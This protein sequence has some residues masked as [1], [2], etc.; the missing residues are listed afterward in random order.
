MAKT[1]KSQSNE[2]YSLDDVVDCQF[3]DPLK[4]EALEPR[5][6]PYWHWIKKCRHLGIHKSDDRICNWTARILTKDKRYIQKYLG[7]AIDTGRGVIDL[8]TAALRAFEWFETGE[9]KGIA[10]HARPT[11]RTSSVN[12]CPIGDTYTVGHALKEYTEWTKIARSEGGHYNNLMLINYHL[13]PRFIHILLENF[14]ATH[15]KDLAIQVLETPPKYGFAHVKPRIDPH[16]LNVDQVRKR[17]RT[18][19]SLVT[20]LRMAFRHA[21]DNGYI[22][23]ERP[24]RCLKRIAV[25]HSPRT[26][27]LTR[28]ECNS[29]L[30][31]CTPAL[32]TLVMAALYSGARVGELGRLTV[33][34]VGKIGY[35]IRIDAFKRSPARFVFLP[36]EGMSFFLE[37]CKGK[38]HRDHVFR[39]DMGKVWKKQHTTLFRRAVSKAG[40]PKE[41]V[42]HGLRHT[43]AS[44]LVR[45][46]VPVDIVAR[47]LG[48]SS[49]RTVIDTYGHFAEHHRER[50]IRKCFSPLSSHQRKK[51]HEMRHELDKL[52][53]TIQPVNWRDYANL[54]QETSK[55]LR[56]V[57]QTSKDVLEVFDRVST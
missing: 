36:D 22:D 35:G 1:Q 33:Q 8:E 32:K 20:I 51:S 34:D 5:A 27:F 41:L 42:F 11:G 48:H 21:W 39:S 15:L 18:F 13:A 25:V 28:E 49:T 57:V 46:G 19:N 30:Q 52:W 44:D 45:S 50:I 26:V 9:I 31:N 6:S 2:T 10:N 14:N 54:N 24:W 43:Y 47:Q 7:P 23:S 40:L 55:P 29:L 38:S 37:N 53:Q 12:F 4:I 3:A 16:E 56:S 17:K